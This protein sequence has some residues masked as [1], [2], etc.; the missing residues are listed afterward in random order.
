MALHPGSGVLRRGQFGRRQ[1]DSC[2]RE[3][4]HVQA[5]AEMGVVRPEAREGQG[6][7]AAPGS[8]ERQQGSSPRASE[9]SVAL[10]TPGFQAAANF[11]KINPCRKLLSVTVAL[12]HQAHTWRALPLLSLAQMH[13][14]QEMSMPFTRPGNLGGLAHSGC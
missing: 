6:W 9:R 10:R 8:W 2:I 7:L 1:R 3:G 11:E 14:S 13:M 5:E 4:G 12:G